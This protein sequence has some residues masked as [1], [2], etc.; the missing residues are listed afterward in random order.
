MEKNLDENGTEYIERHGLFDTHKL[1]EEG[2]KEVTDFKIAFNEFIGLALSKMP[3]GRIKAI[4]KTKIE[5]AAF[6]GTKA[7]AGKDGN[8][9]EIIRY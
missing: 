3:E 2:F 1:N 7:I 5:E 4:F 9:D 8:Y 6:F